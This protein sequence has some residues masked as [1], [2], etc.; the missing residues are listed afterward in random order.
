MSAQQPPHKGFT[1]IELMVAISILAIMAA[2]GGVIYSSAQASARDSRRKEDIADIKKAMYL[3]KATSGSFCVPAV[4][5]NTTSNAYYP[6][7]A[8][9]SGYPTGGITPILAPYLR[10]SPLD[11]QQ[12]TDNT[13]VYG[14]RITGDSTFEVY[15]RLENMTGVT[16]E[17]TPPTD[18]YNHNFV[19]SN[20]EQRSFF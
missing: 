19:L 12:S 14:L 9:Y 16:S 5:C 18:A 15:A 2:I 13:H 11:P 4:D 6:I 17:C 8:F 7:S 10:T 20:N 1:L 3:Y